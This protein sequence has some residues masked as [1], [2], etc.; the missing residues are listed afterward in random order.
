M[1]GEDGA[2]ALLSKG[3]DLSERVYLGIGL[4]NNHE[5]LIIWTGFPTVLSAWAPGSQ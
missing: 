1:W 4:P 5:A 2:C 3:S